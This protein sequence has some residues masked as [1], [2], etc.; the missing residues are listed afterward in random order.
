M[1]DALF[2]VLA[3]VLLGGCVYVLL[4]LTAG[5]K[6]PAVPPPPGVEV[7]YSSLVGRLEEVEDKYNRLDRRFTRLQGEFNALTRLSVD[8][9]EDDSDRTPA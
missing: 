9:E 6:R 5:P 4:R 3:G 2:G 1:S 8:V 7:A